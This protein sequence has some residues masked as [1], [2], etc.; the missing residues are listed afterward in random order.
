VTAANIYGA[1][2]LYFLFTRPI[3]LTGAGVKN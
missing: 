3:R 1:R 2:D